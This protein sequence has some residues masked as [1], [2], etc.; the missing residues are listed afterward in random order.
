[1]PLPLPQID[2]TDFEELV[3]QARGLI[4]R[5]AGE[6]TDHNVHDPGMM[7]IELAA[8]L[9]DQ[10]IYTAGFVSDEHLAAFAAL[11]GVR[12]R[13]ARPAR[14]LIWPDAGAVVNDATA[15]GVDLARGALAVTRQ[16]P[17][18]LFRTS[19]GMH[20]T[21]AT[22]L[23]TP[24]AQVRLT[25]SGDDRA[26]EILFDRP[27]VEAPDVSPYPL[28]LGVEIAGAVQVVNGG[29]SEGHLAVDYRLEASDQ[30]SDLDPWQR[31]ELLDDT[32]GV[33]NRTGV[34]LLRL[35]RMDLEPDPSRKRR[36]R[37]RIRLRY[38]VNPSPPSIRRVGV[39]VVPV[40]QYRNVA[41]ALVGSA[42]G[43]PNQSF[44]L[45]SAGIDESQPPVIEVEEGGRFVQWGRADDF[46]EAAAEQ[47]VY[48]LDESAGRLHFGNG[49]NGRIPQRGAQIRHRDYA[50]TGGASGNLAANLDWHITGAKL[51]TGVERFGT[52]IRPMTGGA[53]AWNAAELRAAARKRATDRLALVSNDDLAAIG[54]ELA[55]LGVA[56]TQVLVG[57]DPVRPH[58]AVPGTRT[59]LVTPGTTLPGS[60]ESYLSALRHTVIPRRVL[61][62]R[63]IVAIK[64]ETLIDVETAVL[65]QDGSDVTAVRE[66]IREMLAARLSML[67]RREDVASWEPGRAV[68]Q[69]ELET[70]IAN[71]NNV[72]SVISCRFARSGEEPDTRPVAIDRDSVA[73]L[74][75][76]S[77][78][79]SVR[80]DRED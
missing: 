63:L 17:D 9:I 33:L 71:T 39:N 47:R 28:T 49:V 73:V 29:G 1:M 65:I 27:L 43:L 62:E 66:S 69:G 67:R 31:V 46:S 34:L 77:L 45:Q 2:T 5:Y 7:L 13:G 3:E 23:A 19:F 25:G 22:V 36:A 68:E 52:N 11:L 50:L 18:I 56:D 20:L 14:G 6:W 30:S 72:M 61:G 4:P 48:V 8:W 60:P 55:T 40:E 58:T 57:F 41:A 78:T 38:R 54:D 26:Y 15:S 42:T 70:L 32:T 64:T 53:D 80:P 44:P 51:N 76:F 16:Q 35:P 21:P 59:L 74:G 24:E 10:Q 12:T 75:A 79:H 37:L